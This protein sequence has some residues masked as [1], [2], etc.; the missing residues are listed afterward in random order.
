MNSM[1]I[2]W[3]KPGLQLPRPDRLNLK[4]RFTS[5]KPGDE[6]YQ[7]ISTLTSTYGISL[8]GPAQKMGTNGRSQNWIFVTNSGKKILK[9]YKPSVDADNILHEHSILSQLALQ[10]FPAPRLNKNL[11]G[12][13]LIEIGNSRFALFDYLD[14]YFQFHEQIYFPSRA[15]TFLALA[16]VSLASLHGTLRDF[17]PVGKN[18]N[19]FLSKDGPRWRDLKWYREQLAV[20]KLQTFEKLRK[21]PQRELNVIHSRAEWIE[22]RLTE[23]DEILAAA[24]LERVIIHGDYGP[25]NLLF[26]NG[27]PVVVIDFE[28]ARLDWPLTDLAYAMTTFARNRLGFQQKKMRQFIQT[29]QEASQ[30]GTEQLDY[31]PDVWEYLSLR[32]F[33]VCWGRALETGHKNWLV[34]AQ[35]RMRMIDWITTH[36]DAMLKLVIR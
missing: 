9:K 19:G 5:S 3:H 22:D 7:W 13:T 20:N 24:P 11:H 15:S 17:T 4:S 34:E 29:Y 6:D 25:Y 28:L 10:Q 2:F 8:L 21:K 1:P 31:L 18:P 26:K 32:R 27:N 23:L 33:I 16:A 36:K 12:E 35:D 30:I 14:G